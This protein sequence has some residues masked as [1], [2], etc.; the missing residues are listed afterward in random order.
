MRPADDNDA[1]LVRK[2]ILDSNVNSAQI[3]RPRS[4]PNS[5]RE[6]VSDRTLDFSQEVEN[7]NTQITILKK[8]PL[9]KA[10]KVLTITPAN[11]NSFQLDLVDKLRVLVR[12]TSNYHTLQVHAYIHIQHE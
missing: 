5:R 10:T 4:A 12:Q 3:S 7:R 8:V 1:L 9:K 11:L 6:K 2:N